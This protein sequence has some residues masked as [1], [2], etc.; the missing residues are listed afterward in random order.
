[1]GSNKHAV[2]YVVLLVASLLIALMAGETIANNKKA[3]G[4]KR[5]AESSGVEASVAGVSREFAKDSFDGSVFYEGFRYEVNTH[6]DTILFLG[7]DSSKQERDGVGITEGGRSDTIILFLLD[8]DNNTV[9]PLEINRDTMVDVDIYD[10]DGKF[11]ARGSEQLTMQ[12][13]Y[14]DTPAKACNLTKEKVSDLLG[15][16]RIDGVISL[17]MDGI[18]PI[19]DSIGGVTLQ[20]QTDETDL[21]PSYTEGA[22]IHLDGVAAKAFVHNRD[23]EVRGSNISR[24]TRQTQFMLALF[25]TIKGQGDSI[26]EIMENAAGDYLYEDVDADSV[27][28]LTNYEYSGEVITLPGENVTDGIHDE[29]Y[30][31]DK[32]L[33]ETV[34]K[35]FYL[36]E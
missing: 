32:K 13:S 18:E 27:S 29:F 34:L 12:Y 23:I 2:K 9:T 1:M 14:G 3:N 33:T 36:K 6:V 31:D 17:T 20:L 35:L 25:Q 11:L 30:V 28:R 4:V 22:V 24:M 21:D 7:I 8:N 16:T 26:V 15:R 10:N 19:V 5:A